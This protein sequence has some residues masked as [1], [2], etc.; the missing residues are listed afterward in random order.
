M[1]LGHSRRTLGPLQQF[2]P[3]RWGKILRIGSVVRIAG[4]GLALALTPST[5]RAALLDCPGT[6]DYHYYE[7]VAWDNDEGSFCQEEDVGGCLNGHY[8]E[9]SRYQCEDGFDCQDTYVDH[10]YVASDGCD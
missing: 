1:M 7:P 10:H 9:T 4:L 8:V 6:E 5:T 2:N 3:S